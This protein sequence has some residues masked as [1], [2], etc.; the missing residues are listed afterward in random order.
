[1]ANVSKK[2]MNNPVIYDLPTHYNGDSFGPIGFVLNYPSGDPV[3][4][5]GCSAAIQ[6][7][8]ADYKHCGPVSME[9]RTDAEDESKRLIISDNKIILPKQ[10]KLR[11]PVSRHEYDLQIT[12]SQDYT[13]TFIKG[14]MNV[15]QD[16]TRIKP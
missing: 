7:R 12:D 8:I 15:S 9:F 14:I 1:M 11:L 13:L 2:N 6:F 4:L 5:T 16:I 10:N 3:N